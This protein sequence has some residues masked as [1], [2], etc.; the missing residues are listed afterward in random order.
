MKLVVLVLVKT[1]VVVSV[2]EV[3]IWEYVEVNT[4]VVFC[5]VVSVICTGRRANGLCGSVKAK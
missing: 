4:T 1:I 5:W 2:E 3:T